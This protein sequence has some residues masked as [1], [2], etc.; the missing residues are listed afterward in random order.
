MKPTAA[1]AIIVNKGK[2]LLGKSTATDFREGK[3]TFVGGGV[4]ERENPIETAVREAREESNA[5]VEAISSP[6]TINSKESVVFV[7]CRY[8]D[9]Q[10]IPNN[11]FSYLGWF[12]QDNLPTDVLTQTSF[13]INGI[14]TGEIKI[15]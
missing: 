8:L 14:K 13:I 9:G 4:D 7:V 1:V 15:F 12:E 5:K 3:W 11:E 2:F 10:I 6:F